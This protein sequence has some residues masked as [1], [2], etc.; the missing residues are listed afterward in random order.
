MR[1]WKI[2]ILIRN[3]KNGRSN[4]TTVTKLRRLWLCIWLRRCLP[5]HSCPWSM[6]RASNVLPTPSD[7]RQC[8]YCIT[9]NWGD[10]VQSIRHWNNC[11]SLGVQPICKK[12]GTRWS[13]RHA[14]QDGLRRASWPWHGYDLPKINRIMHMLQRLRQQLQGYGMRILRNVLLH[15]GCHARRVLKTFWH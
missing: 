8:N 7:T 13:V 11:L 1:K 12:D 4:W 5:T 15:H 6:P 3:R 10:R 9:L 14:Q 2:V